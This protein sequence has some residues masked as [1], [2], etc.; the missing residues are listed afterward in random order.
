MY[1]PQ[2]ASRQIRDMA[3][4]VLIS[5]IFR[6]FACVDASTADACH[7]HEGF[8]SVE[9]TSLLQMGMAMN[10]GNEHHHV[11][12]VQEYI[13]NA[14]AW[15]PRHENIPRLAMLGGG[16]GILLLVAAGVSFGLGLIGKSKD[17]TL[18][19][20]P[21][22]SGSFCAAGDSHLGYAH[23]E[24][25]EGSKDPHEGIKL[26]EGKDKDDKPSM[27]VVLFFRSR[28]CCVCVVLDC[29]EQGCHGK[30]PSS[31]RLWTTSW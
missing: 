27:W 20:S 5:I 6:N 2:F 10:A 14:E 16:M 11:L 3:L 19:R 17:H 21:A 1:W 7:D 13:A 22:P 18:S 8:W 30:V 25:F 29:R 4:V 26:K 15:H 31:S 24:S 23:E 28:T 9:G 12:T